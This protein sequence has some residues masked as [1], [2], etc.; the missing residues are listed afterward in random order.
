M[1]KYNLYYDTIRIIPLNACKLYYKRAI[2]ESEKG[3]SG[4]VANCVLCYVTISYGI[5]YVSPFW[6]IKTNKKPY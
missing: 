4:N 3:E 2:M 6:E 1:E 5:S